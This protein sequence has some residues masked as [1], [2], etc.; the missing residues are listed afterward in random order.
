MS[1]DRHITVTIIVFK[2]NISHGLLAKLESA[3]R[4][5]CPASN[6]EKSSSTVVQTLI[7]YLRL[8]SQQ[9]DHGT[10]QMD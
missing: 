10:F 9:V 5:S 2:L 1:H 6:T 3:R 4:H 7:V 8:K